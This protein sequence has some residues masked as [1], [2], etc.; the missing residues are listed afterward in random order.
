MRFENFVIVMI[1][2][3]TANLAKSKF[4]PD[5]PIS[6]QVLFISFFFGNAEIIQYSRNDSLIPTFLKIEDLNLLAEFAFF[7]LRCK[8]GINRPH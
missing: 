1:N 4:Q 3:F 6:L 2:P 5:V 8:L 7:F